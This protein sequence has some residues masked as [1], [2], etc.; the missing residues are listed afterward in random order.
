MNNIIKKDEFTEK[1]YE[2]N[3][4]NPQI[5]DTKF[6]YTSGR[7]LNPV[8]N[9]Y[10][11]NDYRVFG[12]YTDWSQY[13]G[14]YEGQY[15]DD[16]CGRGID[17]M[18]LDAQALD[19]IVIGFSAI[20]G[21]NGHKKGTIDKAAKD[22]ER[23][24]DQVTFV[25]SWGDV[26]SYRNCG[27]SGWVTNDVMPMFKEETAQGV[28]GGLRLL[29][30]KNPNLVMAL[31]VGGWT[32]SEA[33][34]W[35]AADKDRRKTF[36]DSIID[37]FA[38]FS[39]F[40]EIDLD[41]EYPNA[42]GD[43]KNTWDESDAE[44]FPKLVKD[45]K[46]AFANANRSDVKISIAVSADPKKMKAANII[47]MVKAG[48]YGINLMSYDFFGT[49]WAETVAHHTNIL[50]NG[51][52]KE[53]SLDTAI[54]FLREMNFPMKR[55]FVGFAGYSRNAKNAEIIN[56]SPLRGNY[57]PKT[58]TT[59]GTFES[60]ATEWYDVVANYLDMDNACGRNGFELYTDEQANAD[61]LYNA[62][63]KLFMS[64]ETP[65]TTKAK[66][67]YVKENKLGGMF[68]WTIEHDAGLLINAAREGLG[69][70]LVD[71]KI[72]MSKYYF[73]GKSEKPPITAVITGPKKV[74]SGNEVS[75]S[76]LES[77]S[78]VAQIIQY[79]WK[80]SEGL[81]FAVNDEVLLSFT[82]PKVTEA[83]IFSVTLSVVDEK[84]NRANAVHSFKIMTGLEPVYDIWDKHKEYWAEDRVSWLDDNWEAMWWSLNDE[85]GQP[86][87][88]V[89]AGPNP[90]RKIV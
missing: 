71:K 42:P 76:G 29:K 28:L 26:L 64:I 4:F 69:C 19:K 82:A 3:N 78:S 49:P 8:Y 59:C 62:Q 39:M 31:S 54:K 18:R 60:G 7:V 34:H 53:W 43:T 2:K 15:A 52:N 61:Y 17:L 86:L 1:K 38:R 35:V 68:I 37:I 51:E 50:S 88:G 57:D 70:E 27:F 24:Q 25:D 75:F 73:K 23:S 63:S 48:I 16:E 66:A 9:T 40:T 87:D 56:Y 10:K 47:Q 77:T 32:M 65:R 30:K 85:P 12:Y 5:E 33:F 13:D 72:D 6:S 20:V 81:S 46:F 41:W 22:F 44:N 55:V 45:L 84:G 21:D 74:I 14:R 90:W 11:K 58:G 79:Q 83:K 89:G 80:G 67:E 36:C